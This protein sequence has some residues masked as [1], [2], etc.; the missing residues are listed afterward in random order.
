MRHSKGFKQERHMN[1]TLAEGQ[2][3]EFDP[4]SRDFDALGASLAELATFKEIARD[5]GMKSHYAVFTELEMGADTSE[6]FV[7]AYFSG[8]RDAVHEVV[9]SEGWFN[10]VGDAYW[11]DEKRNFEGKLRDALEPLADEI[12]EASDDED[13]EATDIVDTLVEYLEEALRDVVEDAMREQDTSKIEDCIPP[14]AKTEFIFVPDMGKLSADDLTVNF[15]GYYRSLD[16]IV[17]NLNFLRMLQFFNISVSEYMDAARGY[18]NDIREGEKAAYDAEYPRKLEAEEKRRANR[19][20]IR[21]EAGMEPETCDDPLVEPYVPYPDLDSHDRHGQYWRAIE[22]IENGD[23]TEASKLDLPYTYN[24]DQWNAMVRKLSMGKDVSRPAA[25]SIE[26]LRVIVENCGGDG[27]DVPCFVMH[28]EIADVLA[29][30]LD[31]P[32]LAQGGQIGLHDFGNGAG[33][34]TRT[35]APV[36]LDPATGSWT[37]RIWG[38]SVNKVYDKAS[39]AFKAT[40]EPTDASALWPMVRP[41]VYRHES[42][43]GLS[44]EIFGQFDADGEMEFWVTTYDLEM[45]PAGPFETS[46]VWPS[47]AQAKVAALEALRQDWAETAD[48]RP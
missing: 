35:E 4:T 14:R 34:L 40:V 44:A 43:D 46:E 33:Y 1:F 19:A 5:I 31:G 18:I 39:E 45:E 6:K 22:G 42:N 10:E 17:P 27:G 29:G 2:T 32:L 36:L 24:R 30:R 11:E 38:N 28:A 8:G 25:L 21:A 12:V 3:V 47:L 13:L 41:D 37:A 20:A 26:G 16:A 15:V 9:V 7:D 23:I 48:L